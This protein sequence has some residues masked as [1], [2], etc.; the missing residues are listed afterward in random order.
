MDATLVRRV[1]LAS[2]L[3]TLVGCG[4]KAIDWS[5]PENFLFRE[6]SAKKDD[7]VQLEYWSLVDAPAQAIYDALADVEHYQDFVPGVDSVQLLSVNGNDN[8]KTVQIAQRVIG[9]QANAKVEWKFFP[10]QHRI[11][12]KTLQSNLSRN[13]GTFEIQPSPDGKR[14]LVH[15]NY[16]VRE[17]EG[18]LQAVPI[19]VL[20]AGTR[21]SFLAAARGVKSKATGSPKPAA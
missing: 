4:E 3:V 2:L 1:A 7:G 17:G 19:G 20:A 18:Q 12:F 14:T 6:K 13:D 11:E 8:D 5:A 16:L 10:D 15:S 9:R 21:D